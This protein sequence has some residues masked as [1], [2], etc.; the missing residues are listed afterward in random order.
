MSRLD[1]YYRG[2]DRHPA[3]FP[4]RP[5]QLQA[6]KPS[7][8]RRAASGSGSSDWSSE[9][10]LDASLCSRLPPDI[11]Y[12]IINV[13]DRKTQ[14]AWTLTCRQYGKY[15]C[16]RIRRD[17]HIYASDLRDHAA[18][19]DPRLR[20]RTEVV[21]PLV[22]HCTHTRKK[23]GELVRCL[24]L[25][26]GRINKDLERSSKASDPSNHHDISILLAFLPNLR[27]CVFEGLLL[28]SRFSQLVQVDTLTSLELRSTDEYWNE[29]MDGLWKWSARD[30][31]PDLDHSTFLRL[32]FRILAQMRSLTR[33]NIG[34]LQRVETRSLVEGIAG[35]QLTEL[36][37][38]AAPWMRVPNGW[39]S[40]AGGFT[41]ISP[42]VFFLGHLTPGEGRDPAD[43][44]LSLPSTLKTLIL[45]NRYHHN[46][47]GLHQ[48]LQNAIKSCSTLRC[49]DIGFA[50]EQHIRSFLPSFIQV[51]S[52]H[53]GGDI[54]AC[55]STQV[56]ADFDVRP[57]STGIVSIPFSYP[58]APWKFQF[59]EGPDI[60]DVW[61]Y[62]RQR[63]MK[64]YRSRFTDRHDPYLAPFIWRR[65]KLERVF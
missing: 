39:L 26:F 52:P 64:S 31:I 17:L 49:L 47:D 65:I 28:Q 53:F 18:F 20:L 34:L 42:L 57:G 10:D 60:E 7:S 16:S 2:D 3:A 23:I 56:Y 29:Y 50:R 8:L 24:F 27:A 63:S 45:R 55:S 21:F 43:P 19:D 6:R 59:S 11:I 9:D 40:L 36:R 41:D 13:S 22:R 62:E 32:D 38:S 1:I 15:A 4:S 44:P 58:N 61:R 37:L 54:E 14:H 25:E 48:G 5:R 51:P 33:L 46:I 30:R 35:L 12:H